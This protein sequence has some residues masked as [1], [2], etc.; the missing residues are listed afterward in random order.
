M[1]G[2]RAGRIRAV[3]RLWVRGAAEFAEDRCSA[4]IRGDVQRRGGAR[5]RAAQPEQLHQ[6]RDRPG[7]A[8]TNGKWASERV[9]LFMERICRI[10]AYYIYGMVG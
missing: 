10:V 6:E 8:L 4:S 1:V 2:E 7:D 5:G 3:P 9:P